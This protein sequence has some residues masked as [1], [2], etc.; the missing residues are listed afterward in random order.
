M[1]SDGLDKGIAAHFKIGIL[2]ERRAGRRQ[3]HDRTLAAISAWR[4]AAP[5]QPPCRA[6]RISPLER[7]RP[8]SRR[9]APSPD[10]SDRRV[11]RGEKR[12]QRL[13]AA[14]L[15]DTTGDPVDRIERDSA[16]SA[17]S[18][19]VAFKSLMKACRRH[20]PTCCMRCAGPGKLFM[21]A[22]ILAGST[23]KRSRRT[24][25][26]AGILPIVLPFSAGMSRRSISACVRPSRRSRRIPSRAQT[27]SPRPFTTETGAC[28]P[29]LGRR[30]DRRAPSIVDAAQRCIARP[31]F[32]EH[33]RLHRGI[34]SIVPCRSR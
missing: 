25:G 2:I 10:Q 13:D 34:S 23:P 27:P 11:Q 3:Q 29:R 4:R 16:F 17:A 14:C 21:A 20:A 7:F 28:R 6:C 18:A 8:A 26:H 12:P 30:R 33:A 15:G 32:G 1:C 24:V 5:P 9:I 22:S 31:L 19:F